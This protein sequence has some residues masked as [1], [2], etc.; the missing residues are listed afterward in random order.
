MKAI[1]NELARQQASFN[2]VINHKTTK[3]ESNSQRLI[4]AG[5]EWASC[6]QS[7]NYKI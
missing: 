5:Y 6:H 2:V 4:N 1:H 3:F 7:Q